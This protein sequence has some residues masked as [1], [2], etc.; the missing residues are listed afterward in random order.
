MRFK[1]MK[2]TKETQ[3]RIL[4]SGYYQGYKYMIVSHGI[5]PTAYVSIP[6]GHCCYKKDYS[7]IDLDVHGG[8]TYSGKPLWEEINEYWIGW[9]YAHAG[10]FLPGLKTRGKKW[11]TRKIFKDVKSVVAQLLDIEYEVLAEAKTNGLNI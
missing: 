3:Y 10:D 9:D 4:A 7:K 2:Y 6:E 11:T 8:L 1:R 5:H